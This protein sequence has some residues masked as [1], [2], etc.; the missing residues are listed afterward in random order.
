MH[1]TFG[2]NLILCLIRVPRFFLI[3]GFLTRAEGLALYR[4]AGQVPDGGHILEIGSWKGK[5]AYCLGRGAKPGIRLT[6]VDPFDGRGDTKSEHV[7]RKKKPTLLNEIIKI[8]LKCLENKIKLNIVQGTTKNIH[9][10]SACLDLVFLDGDHS[11]KAVFEDF[12]RISPFL[13]NGSLFLMHDT[14]PWSPTAGPRLLAEYLRNSGQLTILEQVDSLLIT[15]YNLSEN[16]RAQLGR[17][18][19]KSGQISIK[20]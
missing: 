19:T 13:K 3:D 11:E 14:A 8:N 12:S 4:W 5:S 17:P 1:R 2:L 9:F 16:K 18:D 15:S 20:A 6:L 7:Y 10:P